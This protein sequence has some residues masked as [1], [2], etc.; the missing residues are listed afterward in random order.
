MKVYNWYGV[1][2]QVTETYEARTGV[3]MARIRAISEVPVPFYPSL[4]KV[5]YSL[6]KQA[7]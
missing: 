1:K 6:L 7:I 3:L 4:E 2:V 5:P